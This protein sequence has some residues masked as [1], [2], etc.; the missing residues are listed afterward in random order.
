MS[1]ST[2]FTHADL[3]N[4]PEDSKRREI[5]DGELFVTP[6]P[7]IPHQK[8]LLRLTSA[9]TTYLDKHPL[10]DLIISPMDV[11]FSDFDVL[12]PDLLFVLNEHKEILKDWVR[13]APDL[14]VEIL[15]PTTEARDRGIK[16]KAYAKFGV[17]EYWIVDPDSR[18][19]EIY[20]LA[21][22]AY[23]LAQTCREAESLTTTLLPGFTCPL[24]SIFR[25]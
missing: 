5:I 20:R 24:A 6:A 22:K 1:I 8:I 7:R 16:L 10:G 11:I 9:I 17:Q 13:G 14:V 19:I 21:K 15:S 3:L 18:A 23:K 25:L 12:Q 4:C 2:K